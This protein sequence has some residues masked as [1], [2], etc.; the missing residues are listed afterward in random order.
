MGW[1]AFGLTFLKDAFLAIGQAKL[2]SPYALASPSEV[3]LALLS[4]ALLALLNTH[5]VL[6][7]LLKANLVPLSVALAL[8]FNEACLASLSACTT[9]AS[10]AE[11]PLKG[12]LA[13]ASLE[14]RGFILTLL[15]TTPGSVTSWPGLLEQLC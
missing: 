15:R 14:K 4:S 10:L 1:K 2:A 9:L 11:A 7:Y 3:V 5:D 13:L 6:A 12:A 8:A